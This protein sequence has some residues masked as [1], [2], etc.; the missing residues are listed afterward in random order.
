MTFREKFP[1]ECYPFSDELCL[2]MDQHPEFFRSL[3]L[4]N[5][6][7]FKFIPLIFI[8]HTPPSHARSK[9]EVIGMWYLDTHKIKCP[10]HKCI[11]LFKQDFVVNIGKYD[12]KFISY[13]ADNRNG[14]YVRPIKEFFDRYGDNGKFYHDDKEWQ[15][16]YADVHFLPDEPKLRQCAQILKSY[17]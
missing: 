9:D 3:K 12:R 13:S 8:S 11:C 10:Q 17:I 2:F 6:K 15:H 1:K 5:P 7:R 14:E 16:H 4:S